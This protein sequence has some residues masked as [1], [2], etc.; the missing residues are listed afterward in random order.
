MI[1][2]PHK[3][4]RRH[5]VLNPWG[6]LLL[7]LILVETRERTHEGKERAEDANSVAAWVELP[8]RFSV[9]TISV[10]GRSICCFMRGPPRET[11][12]S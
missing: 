4:T 8:V 1:Q 2:L 12:T 6:F 10:M 9:T 7:K 11:R 5:K 3:A